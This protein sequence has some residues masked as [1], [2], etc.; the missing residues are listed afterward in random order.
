MSVADNLIV[1][2]VPL[3]AVLELVA[4]PDPPVKPLLS[5][6]ILALKTAWLRDSSPDNTAPDPAPTT[7]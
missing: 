4:Y 5:V 7:S 2:V 6:V 1:F 3:C